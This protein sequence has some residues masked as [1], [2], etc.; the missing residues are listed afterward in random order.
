MVL[1]RTG[2]TSMLGL[3][4]NWSFG[5][6]SYWRRDMGL[7]ED[8]RRTLEDS[9]NQNSFPVEFLLG[10]GL[11]KQAARRAAVLL[12]LLHYTPS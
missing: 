5:G 8:T 6:G 4:I 11:S 9:S 1:E 10:A 2:L 12:S 7:K 3:R